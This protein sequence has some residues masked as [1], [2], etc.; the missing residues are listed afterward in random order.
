MATTTRANSETTW[1]HG[2]RSAMDDPRWSMYAG[3]VGL[4]LAD[5]LTTAMVLDRGGS[6]RNP[7]VQPLVD[8]MWQVAGLKAVVLVLIAAL[9]SRCRGSRIAEFSVAATTGWYLAV[10]LWNIAVLT[11]L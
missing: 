8:N 3:L 6:E 4:N 7:F 2:V 11:I 10:V 9:L 5:V 1:I